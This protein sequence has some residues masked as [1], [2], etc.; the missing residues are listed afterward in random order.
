MPHP[1]RVENQC[2]RKP[3]KL[4]LKVNFIAILNESLT[5]PINKLKTTLS[6]TSFRGAGMNK[7]AKAGIKEG[8]EATREKYSTN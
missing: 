1:F 4:K 3:I 5:R 2:H 8:R 7:I 6:F